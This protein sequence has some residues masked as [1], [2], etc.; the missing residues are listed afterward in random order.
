MKFL[1]GVSSLSSITGGVMNAGVVP[2]QRIFS[3]LLTAR[4]GGAV[5]LPLTGVITIAE[6]QFTSPLVVGD[7]VLA[8]AYATAL[9]GAT[10]GASMMRLRAEG[11]TGT[12]LSGD[13]EVDFPARQ[14]NHLAGGNWSV[15]IPGLFR[16]TAPGTCHIRLDGQSNV[17]TSDVGAGN[18]EI[19]GVVLPSQ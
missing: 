12:F 7:L 13:T 5:T 4:N 1:G 18:C 2:W 19:I 11:G 3:E 16:C 9:K 10:D 14:S 15:V 8:I 6:I 17:T